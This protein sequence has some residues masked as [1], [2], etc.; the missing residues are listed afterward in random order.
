VAIAHFCDASKGGSVDVHR[1][2]VGAWAELAG[3]GDELLE[4]HLLAVG[5]PVRA[6]GAQPPW[7][8]LPGGAAA[9]DGDEERVSARWARERRVAA[10]EDHQLPVRGDAWRLQGTGVGSKLPQDG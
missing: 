7:G 2:E 10:V 3:A 6:S 9:Y 4:Q 1:V 5:R 8:E